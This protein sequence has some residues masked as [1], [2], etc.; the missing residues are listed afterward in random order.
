MSA[1]DLKEMSAEEKVRT[2]VRIAEELVLWKDTIH[3]LSTGVYGVR[4][5]DML[6][7]IYVERGADAVRAAQLRIKLLAES[8]SIAG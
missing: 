4:G 6:L 3:C 7:T 2:A 1:E 5:A 8:N